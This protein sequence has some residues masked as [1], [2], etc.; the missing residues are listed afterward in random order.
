LVLPTFAEGLPVVIMEAMALRRPVADDLCGWGSPS[1]SAGEN[2][3]LFPA[4]DVDELAAA[5]KD[6]L[7]RFLAKKLQV[8]GEAA[9]A[10]VL[11]RHSIDTEA[12]K[13]GALFREVNRHGERSAVI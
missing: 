5:I 7:S 1:W 8:M 6:L 3:W 4:G 10:R 11:E 12:A 13:L 2:G 9:R